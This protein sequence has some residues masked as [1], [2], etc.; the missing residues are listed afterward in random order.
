MGIMDH[1]LAT[2]VEEIIMIMNIVIKDSD[3]LV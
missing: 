1:L 3:D 2:I